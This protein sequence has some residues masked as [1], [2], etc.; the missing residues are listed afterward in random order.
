MGP[1]YTIRR[2]DARDAA[3][4]A[5][6]RAAMFR[7]M[8]AVTHAEAAALERAS[9]P[10]IAGLF[11]N[12]GY[13]GWIA[14]CEGRAVAGGGV[15]LRRIGPTP[16][17]LEGA[18]W[19]HVVNVYTEPGHRRRGLARRLMHAILEWC[20]QSGYRHV[21]LAASAEGRPLYESLGFVATNEMR[22]RQGAAG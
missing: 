15:L 1:V 7:D 8:G 11:A 19:A 3:L 20:A 13:A 6:H 16:G 9:G 22:L 10:W 21:T 2:A 5:H 14:E 17:Y 4:I 18:P 12:G